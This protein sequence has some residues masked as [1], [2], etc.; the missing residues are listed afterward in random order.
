MGPSPRWDHAMSFDS[1]RGCMFGGED[2][3]TESDT[4]FRRHVTGQTVGDTWELP[5][6]AAAAGTSA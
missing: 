3:P 1:D 5:V 2:D 4:F 6:P